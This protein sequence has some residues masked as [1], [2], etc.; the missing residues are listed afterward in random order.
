MKPSRSDEVLPPEEQAAA[1]AKVEQYFES[2][3]PRRAPKPSRSEAGEGGAVLGAGDAVAVDLPERRA[4][5]HLVAHSG[6]VCPV[7]TPEVA[8]PEH[9]PATSY[10]EHLHFDGPHCPTGKGFIKLDAKAEVPVH[11]VEH[12]APPPPL[13]V[14]SHPHTNPARDDWAP[15]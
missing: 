9:H 11:V 6:P 10:Y 12:H 8:D 15:E 1:T 7:G 13:L 14:H 3:A 2:Q 5:A 4:L